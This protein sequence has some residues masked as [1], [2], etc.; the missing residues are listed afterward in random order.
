MFMVEECCTS[1]WVADLCLWYRNAVPVG[2]W[3]AYVYGREMLFQG[4]G[5]QPTFIVEECCTS[6][7]VAGLCL[8]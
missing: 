1:R 6:G 3:P 7:W 4:V 5:G 8:W 2:G